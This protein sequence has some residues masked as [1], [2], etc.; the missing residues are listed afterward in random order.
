MNDPTR[1]RED[2]MAEAAGASENRD[3]EFHQTRG[4]RYVELFAVGDEW[5][6]V[7]NSIGLSDGPPD[8]W[9]ATDAAEA[10]EKLGAARVVKNG[11]HWWMSDRLT[12]RFSVEETVI[13]GIGYRIVAR[14]PAFIAKS[15]SVEPP[16]Y[17]VNVANKQGVNVYEAGESVYELVSQDGDAFVMQ[18]SNIPPDEVPKLG[19]RLKPP[20][21]WAFR[22]RRLDKELTLTMDGQVKV[23]ADELK[24][25]YN[26][27]PREGAPDDQADAKDLDVRIAA[28]PGPK[29]A[30]ED[31]DRFVALAGSVGIE[32]VVLMTRDEH[33]EVQVQETGD[34]AGKK[35]AK[36]GGGIGL[37]VGLFSPPL[38]AATAVGAAGGAIAG[39]FA[40]K[41]A[42]HGIAEKMDESLPPDAA[43]I[44]AIYDHAHRSDADAA[45]A[46]AF[47]TT[48]VGIDHASAKELKAALG[49]S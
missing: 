16:H 29:S 34:H 15:G 37:V 11:P 12:V 9:E 17:S 45:L 33:G 35:G 18:S 13:N 5:I 19:D 23:V 46:N 48:I 2:D 1:R 38:L 6:T 30:K 10:A 24:N 7:Y 43:G 20:E 40:K 49:E 26:E 14:L 27:P 41:R 8:L 25:I 47:K 39:H 44:L 22:S 21:G 31:F 4:L 36:V 3:F 42:A 28:Y 32:G